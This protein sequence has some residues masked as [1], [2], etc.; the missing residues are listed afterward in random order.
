[1]GIPKKYTDLVGTQQPMRG[2]LFSYKREEPEA[3][4][5]VLDIKAGHATVVNIQELQEK[6]ESSYEHPTFHLLVKRDGMKRARWTKAF[7]IREI[8]LKE[9]G[10]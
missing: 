1:M 8:N 5:D 2:G 3:T 10:L 9:A 7:A 6:G 4:Y